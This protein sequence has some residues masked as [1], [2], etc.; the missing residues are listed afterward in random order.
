MH[1]CQRC[2]QQVRPASEPG[3]VYAVELVRT[4]AQLG[5]T[6]EYVEAL[7]VFFHED[8]FPEGSPAYRRKPMPEGVEDGDD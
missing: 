4:V 3:I 5:P 7:G 2:R 6:I 8:C 1:V